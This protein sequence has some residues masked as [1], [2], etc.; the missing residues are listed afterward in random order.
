[1]GCVLPTAMGAALDELSVERSGSGSA[2]VQALRQAGGTIGVAVLGTVLST[3]YR[4]G[5]G[6]P[7]RPAVQRRR[8]PG[9]RGRR[10][11]WGGHN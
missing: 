1:M 11:R 5:L 4:N 8:H 7:G 6:R 9:H 3:A 10:A 2:L